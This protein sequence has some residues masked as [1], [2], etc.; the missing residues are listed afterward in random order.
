MP[1]PYILVMRKSFPTGL[2]DRMLRIDEGE[3]DPSVWIPAE[4]VFEELTR[5]LDDLRRDAKDTD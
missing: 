5:D 3:R 4:K 2:D 1:L